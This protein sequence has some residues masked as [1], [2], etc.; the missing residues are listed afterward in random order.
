MVLISKDKKILW[1]N[2]AYARAVSSIPEDLI[3]VDCCDLF[4]DQRSPIS[5]CVHKKVFET[6]RGFTEEV[7]DDE[8]GM[9]ALVTCTPYKN[10]KGE[11]RGTLVIARDITE[12]KEKENEIRYL[13]EFNENIV[14][15]LGDGLEIIGP[16]HKIQYMNQ[17]FLQSV[18][19]DV[20]GKTCY[21]VHFD[22]DSPCEGCPIQ[23][24]L[25]NMECETLECETSEEKK[26][27]ITHSPLK[28]QDGS[29]SAILL[30]KNIE[31]MNKLPMQDSQE[32]GP[33]GEEN[34][35]ISSLISGIRHE[36]TNPLGGIVECGEALSDEDDPL[37]IRLHAK[38]IQD[39]ASRINK[40]LDSLSHMARIKSIS[41][42]DAVDLNEI[43]INS[44]NTMNQH[45]NFA[46]M[47][48]ETDLSPVPKIHGDPLEIIQVFIN[49]ITNSLENM[50]GQGKIR[51]STKCENG[52]I[53]LVFRD[54]GSEIPKEHLDKIFDPFYGI[55]ESTEGTGG[56]G[57]KTGL[58][59]YTVSKILKKYNAPISV[60]SN[61]GMGTAFTISFPHHEEDIKNT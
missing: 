35:K 20:I 53:K 21:E 3:G 25:E 51:I 14:E 17:S 15:N 2:I 60:E 59:M 13:K 30:F 57:K 27:L 46:N 41:V 7:Y 56:N 47:E 22:S 1:V 12:K 43:I 36:M 6:N 37:K 16:D 45:E 39:S 9:T 52:S 34:P 54:T 19:K 4:H 55:H 18:G 40:L 38:E 61:E 29:H 50:K 26:Y 32:Q 11:L 23:G 24:G 8:T 5:K 28:N 44:L 31:D 33:Q 48:V 49:L 10:A 58:R 42:V